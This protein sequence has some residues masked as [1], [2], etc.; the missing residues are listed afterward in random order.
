M[1]ALFRNAFLADED[2]LCLHCG[3]PVELPADYCGECSAIAMARGSAETDCPSPVPQD[4]QARAESIAQPYP[5]TTHDLH[6]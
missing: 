4:C 2:D 6:Q 1:S 5:E 3:T